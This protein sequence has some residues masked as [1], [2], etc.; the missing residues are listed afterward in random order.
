MLNGLQK[1]QVLNKLKKDID[2][3]F[4]YIDKHYNKGINNENRF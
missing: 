4:E 2:F 1:A 3:C